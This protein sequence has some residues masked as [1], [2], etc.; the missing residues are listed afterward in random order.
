ML[1]RSHSVYLVGNRE[2]AAV[3]QHRRE[4]IQRQENSLFERAGKDWEARQ[5]MTNTNELLSFAKSPRLTQHVSI[6]I[7]LSATFSHYGLLINDERGNNGEI[8]IECVSSLA[9]MAG[10]GDILLSFVNPEWFGFIR[11]PQIQHFTDNRDFW[12]GGVNIQ[13][14]PTQFFADGPDHMYNLPGSLA[15]QARIFYF[16]RLF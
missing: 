4:Y 9:K 15:F 2:S 5:S 1:R 13:F 14:R 12:D 7:G 6:P 16:G 8:D 11:L 10:V 3:V